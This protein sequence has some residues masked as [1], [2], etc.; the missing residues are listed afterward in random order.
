MNEKDLKILG[1]LR[2]DARMTLTNISR[3]TDIP[4]TTIFDRIRGYENRLVTKYSPL[5]DFEKLGYGI[6]AFLT[7]S[8]ESDHADNLEHFIRSHPNINSIFQIGTG[9]TFVCEVIFQDEAGLMDLIMSLKEGYR[10]K[11]VTADF[12][13]RDLKREEFMSAAIA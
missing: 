7:V 4:I 12:I 13:A 1:L 9:K 8:V 6:R 5:I 11:D 2:K 3:M 10:A